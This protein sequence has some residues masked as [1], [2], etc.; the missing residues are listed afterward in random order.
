MLSDIRKRVRVIMFVVAVAFVAGFLMGEVW[1]MLA[2]RGTGRTRDTQG[3]VGQVGKHKITPEEYRN[4]SRYITDKYKD[5]NQLRDLS[6]EDYQKIE[7][8]TWKFL[9]SELTWAKVLEKANIFV[10]E[11]EVMELIRN[12]PPPELREKPEL[13]TDGKFDYEKYMQVMNAP[14]NREYFYNYFR[15]L[16]DAL[17]KEKFRIDILSAYRVT[18]P[19]T[20]DGL[21]AANGRWKVTSLYFGPRALGEKVEPSEAE[22][23]DWYDA[24]REDFRTKEMRQLRYVLFPLAVSREDSAAAKE[25]ID[26]AYAQLLTGETFNL[27]V[28]DYSD[29]EGDTLPAL[30]PRAGLDKLTDSILSGLNPGRYS[31]P[32]LAGYGWQIVLLDSLKEDSV[33]FRRIIVRVKMGNEVLAAA[34]DSVRSFF[35]ATAAEKFD[36]VAARF[37]LALQA[38]RPLVGDQKELPGLPVD[39]QLTLIEWARAANPGQVFDLPQRGPGGYYVFELAEVRPAGVQEFEKIKQAATW[40]VRQEREKQAWTAMASQALDAVKTGK[41]FEQYAQ[42]NPGAEL[43]TEEFNGLPDCRRKKGPEFA[44]AL[45]ALNPGEKCGPVEADW[46][47]FIIRC[48]ERTSTG[49]LDAANYADQRTQQV[50]QYLMQ[51]ML[52]EPEVRD[53]RNALAY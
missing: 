2:T 6:N 12:N 4:A 30:T 8:Q 32:F 21:R 41:S 51:E 38:A 31:P 22:A 25:I 37:G 49:T 24:H 36:T 48:D 46:G 44:G 1:R 19:E 47:A 43:Q 10:T 5:D 29:M 13:T 28:I 42:E 34:R 45:A 23:R 53:Y 3:Y 17:P 7:Q 9:V 52:T 20:E 14:E 18:E 39:N 35:E 40:R 33:S 11:E 26:R 27:T 16:I 50:A 15:E